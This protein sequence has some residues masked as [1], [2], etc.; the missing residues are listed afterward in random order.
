M[1]LNTDPRPGW[2]TDQI[3]PH[4]ILAL[5]TEGRRVAYT[6]TGG[7]GPVLLMVHVGLWSLLW[8]GLIDELAGRYRCVTLD[9]PGSGLSDGGARGGLDDAARAVKALIDHLDLREVTLVVH[10]L[11]GLAALA[12]VAD[13]ADR[14]AGLVAM[15]TF[16]WAPRGVLRAALRVFGSAAMREL[17]AR[18][19]LL[20][21]GSATRFGVGRRWDRATRRAWR[22][23]LRDGDRRR[24]P[25][26]VFADA[27]GD[28]RVPDA[29]AAAVAAL[30]GRPTLT[31]FG[32]LGDYFFFRRRWRALRPD[33]SEAVVPWGLHFP[34]A[35]N[36]ALVAGQIHAW[37]RAQVRGS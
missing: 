14:V 28:R 6:D 5:D 32:Q 11:G 4:P 33:L 31:V 20:A 29:A 24:F 36:P 2:L 30:A 34:M 7:D 19:G 15:N 22:R 9:V 16:G 18:L 13:Q 26:Q 27:A 35:D 17:N 3:W 10:D 1:D 23:G 37:H 21:W 12:A 25:H 8:R